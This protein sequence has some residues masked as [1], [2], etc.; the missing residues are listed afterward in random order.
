MATKKFGEWEFDPIKETGIKVPKDRVE[1]ALE[2]VATVVKEAVLS[3]TADLKPSVQDGRWVESLRPAY[4]KRKAEE[5]SV[6]KANLELTG[7]LLDSLKTG[8]SGRKVFIEV[9]EEER[10]KAEGHLTGKYGKHSAIRPRQFMP[11]G[12]QK[13]A[14][15]IMDQVRK[16]LRRFEEK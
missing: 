8:V 3:R 16:V 4:A 11:V 1:E 13:L 6:D 10:G 12:N 5:S 15:P 9:A 14:K 7:D 2:E